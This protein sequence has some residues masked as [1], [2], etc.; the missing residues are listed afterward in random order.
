[1]KKYWTLLIAIFSFLNAQAEGEKEP[2]RTLDIDNGNPSKL[3][4]W[5]SMIGFRNTLVF[6]T[7]DDQK[8]VVKL[9]IGNQDTKFPVKTTIYLFPENTT[10]KGIGKWLNNQHSDGLFPDVPRP[11]KMIEIDNKASVKN[12]KEL[13]KKELRGKKFIAYEVNIEVDAF[14]D[15]TNVKLNS[16]KLTTKVHVPVK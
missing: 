16:F 5:H 8:A 4:V 11:E 9:N 10:A 7:F 13:E 12:F 1:M 15:K 6:Y 14:S 3:E 2:M